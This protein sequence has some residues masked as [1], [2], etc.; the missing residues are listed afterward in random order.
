MSPPAA[1]AAAPVLAPLAAPLD[2]QETRA[3]QH[4]RIPKIKI[5]FGK[6]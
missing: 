1:P 6:L 3:K 2:P 5:Y 4:M